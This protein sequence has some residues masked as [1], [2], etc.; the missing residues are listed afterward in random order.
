M[1]LQAR[2]VPQDQ[3]GFPAREELLG[4]KEHLDLPDLKA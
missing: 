2:R 4:Y 1:E 3:L